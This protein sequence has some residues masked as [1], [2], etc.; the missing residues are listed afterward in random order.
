MKKFLLITRKHSI[1]MRA[2]LLRSAVQCS[3]SMTTRCQHQWTE[4][5][6]GP[7]V[8]KFELVS[9]DGHQMQQRGA[10]VPKVN[11]FE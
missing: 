10:G 11:K 8:N 9:S 2:P 4:W 1:R 5:E 6:G 3:A 7:E